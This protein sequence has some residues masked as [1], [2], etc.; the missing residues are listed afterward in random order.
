M[1]TFQKSNPSSRQW[2][3]T[4]LLGI[5]YSSQAATF[6][7]STKLVSVSIFCWLYGDAPLQPSALQWY[8]VNQSYLTWSVHSSLMA[9]LTQQSWQLRSVIALV[10][11]VSQGFRARQQL[12][13]F[14]PERW[15]FDTEQPCNRGLTGISLFLLLPS[16]GDE[17]RE[18]TGAGLRSVL[19]RP[20]ASLS[21]AV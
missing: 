6:Y 13:H 8:W 3:L 5:I 21:M 7:I 11:V 12:G 19:G 16:E 15:W 10:V 9:H 17:Q 18:P 2:T 1:V 20:P 14:A 4:W